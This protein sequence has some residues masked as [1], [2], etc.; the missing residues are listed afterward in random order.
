MI[1]N[2]AKL[3][4]R[5]QDVKCDSIIENMEKLRKKDNL[6][7]KLKEIEASREE[8]KGNILDQWLGELI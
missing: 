6:G 5:M 7:A 3:A 2:T 4:N 1:N 8:K